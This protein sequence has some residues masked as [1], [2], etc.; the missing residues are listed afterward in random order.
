MA[1]NTTTRQTTAFTSGNNFAFA[2]KVYEVGDV[3]VIQIQTSNG[4]ETVLTITTNY[5]VTLNDDQN[6]NPGGTVTLVSSGSAQNLASGY[7]IVITSKV[8]PLQQT[9]IT[10]QGGFFP[11]VIN[12]VFDKAVILDQQQQSVIDKTIRFPITQTVGGLEITENATDRANKS[13][14][15]DSS[16]DLELY[17][18]SSVNEF[19]TAEKNKLAGIEASATADQTASEIRTLVESATD[20]NV[21]TDADHTKLNAIEASAT[22]DQTGAEIKTAYEAESNT[23]AFTDAEKTKLSGVASSANNYSISSDLLDEDNMASNSATK[24]ASQQ[25]IKAYVDANSGTTNLTST[26]NGTSL[27]VESSSGNNASLP[28]ATTSAWG[29]M[30]D[31]DKTKLDGIETNATADQTAAEI[32]TLVESASDSNVFTDADHTKLNAIEAS[33]DVTDATNVD[34]AG[35]VMNSDSTTAGMSFVVDEDNM[36]SNSATKVPTQQSVK[37]YVDTEVAGVVD[38]APSALNTLNEL[39]AALGDDANFSTTITNSIGTKLPLAGGTMTG[40]IVMSSSQT[41]DGRDLSVDG[42]KLDGIEASADVTDAT[43]V[44]AAGAVMNSDLDGKGELLVGDGSGDPTALA[45]GTNGYVLKANS[46]TA[47]GLEWSAAGSG[48]DVNQNAFSN[49]AVSGQDTVAADSA[50]DTLNIA[51]GSNVTITTTAGSDTVTIASTDTN[52]TYS[53]GDGGLSQNNFTDAL[54][55]KLDGIAASANVGLTDIVGDTTPQ[56]G[57]NLD[58]QAREI[59]T[60]TTN[61]NIVLNPNGEF[62]VVRI[63]GDSTNSIDGTLE[64]RCSSDSHGVKIKSPPH[65]AAQNYTLTLPSSIVNGAFLKTDSNGGLSFATPTDTNTQLSNAEVRTAVEAASDS[66]VFTDADH[67]KLN[68][69]AASANN[70]VHPNHSG[71]VTSTADGATV[72]ADNVVDEAN[73]KVSNTPTNGYVL[74]A[75]SGNTGGLTWAAQSGGGGT[76]T[77]QDEGN[78]TGD[79]ADTLNFVGTNIAVTGSGS[80]KTI[81][82]TSSSGLA[83]DAYNNT[84]G[85]T[86][87]LTNAG[88]GTNAN[89]AFGKQALTALNGGQYSDAFG[90][91]ALRVATTGI[92]NASVGCFSGY[93]I[94]TGG[95]NSTFGYYSGNNITTGSNNI[96]I[97]NST[98]ASTATVSNEITLGNSSIT[99]FRVPGLNFVIKDST[100]TDNYVLTVDSNG[101][102]GWEAASG[103]GG[104]LSSDAQNNTVG[105]S[106]AG[107]SITNGTNNT[108]FG[109]NA[110]TAT[111]AQN[112]ST[113]FG[114][115]ALAAATTNSGDNSAFGHEAGKTITSG[116]ANTLLGRRA[117]Q[118]ITNETGNVVAGFM[119]DTEGS[120]NVILGQQAGQNSTGGN[121]VVIGTFA[122]QDFTGASNHYIGYQSGKDATSSTANVCNG[123][124]SGKALTSGSYNTCLGHEAGKALTTSGYGVYIGYKAGETYSS[125]N[126]FGASAVCV[127]A[128]AGATATGV[129]NTL[130][131]TKAGQNIGSGSN[132]V[133]I[134]NEAGLFGSGSYNVAIG[135]GT[136][137][138]A[139]GAGSNNVAVGFNAGNDVTT[140]DDNTFIGTNAG[141]TVTTGD[142]N[143]ALGH[144]AAPSSNTV[145]N[146]ITLGDSNIATLRCNVQTI[147]SLSDRRDK[148]N[149]NTL[150]LGLDFVK[151]L[152]PV[153]FK[154]ETRDGNGKDGSYEAGF[155]AQDFQQ[156]QKDNDADYLKLVMDTN[157][158]RL[159]ASYGKLIPVLVKAIQELTIEVETLKSNG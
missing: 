91:Q 92:Y 1:I 69:I 82:L 116:T 68:G 101:E 85:G 152:N 43:N 94:T 88:S 130:I 32:R 76:F 147:S 93:N 25:S 98:T 100:A 50:T 150:D 31:D 80:T 59:T 38:S 52:T 73:L 47:T 24:A 132:C 51:A 149:I 145:S 11:E 62:G 110:G 17:N 30:T 12:D 153:K 46:S 140:G 54:K 53:V 154:W 119:A 108:F 151:S 39:A 102:A 74:T 18:Q 41:V 159:E 158:D 57:G 125:E 128:Q 60:S 3:K 66:N 155:I 2:F 77:V 137:S 13:F 129:K 89:T 48:G 70:Y 6:A 20:S 143:I 90:Y 133:I 124:E 22:A 122:G 134:G 16:G 37:A 104:G 115:E 117:G 79:A 157:P 103:G 106:N 131:G 63:K 8:S 139:S 156:L 105:G 123:R 40:N 14:R 81:T 109:Y 87:A 45:A 99:K 113:A 5:T 29:V 96:V 23:N 27:T 7:N 44:N 78:S 65:S 112:R 15:F 118:S 71:E 95:S 9:E 142:N 55:T 67:T 127:G 33:A 83:S 141:D 136:L 72:I 36:S 126:Q 121:S 4:A 135:G 26:A 28:A 75:Q 64:L 42:T 148:T 34:A 138:A 86:D 97:G 146:E 120:Y 84:I 111:T 10:N 49:I 56:L 114:S 61:G 58:V 107:D 144:D 21:F 19:T 35:A